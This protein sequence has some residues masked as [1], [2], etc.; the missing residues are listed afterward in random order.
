MLGVRAVLPLAVRLVLERRLADATGSRVE[1]DD[2]DLGLLYGAVRLEGIAFRA[3]SPEDAGAP[4]AAPRAA[5]TASGGSTDPRPTTPTQGADA[6]PPTGPSAVPPWLS[7]KSLEVRI[8]WTGLWGRLLRVQSLVLVE[9]AL[10]VSRLEGGG[11]DVPLPRVGGASR[12]AGPDGGW[13]LAV[14]DAELR[15]GRVRFRDLTVAAPGPVK[16]DL[17]RVELSDLSLGGPA[18][19]G[20]ARLV[21]EG[22]IEGAP[23]HAEASL[24]RVASGPPQAGETN[25]GAAQADGTAPGSGPDAADAERAWKATASLEA[26]GVPIRRARF[27]L[28]PRY[29]PSRRWAELDGALDLDLRGTYAP[30][31]G[32]VVDGTAALRDVRVRVRDEDRD[33]VAWRRLAVEAKRIDLRARRAE[34]ASLELDGGRLLVRTGAGG[35]VPLLDAAAAEPAAAPAPAADGTAPGPDPAGASGPP[36]DEG[37]ATW[38]GTLAQARVH[39]S[40]LELV[41]AE[42]AS[43]AWSVE[44]RAEDVRPDDS[45]PVHVE[46]AKGDAAIS[47]EG[48][49]RAAPPGGALDLHLEQLP[50]AE[51]LHDVAPGRVPGLR[52]GTLAGRLHLETPAD[53]ARRLLARGTLSVAD[54]RVQAADPEDFALRWKRVEAQLRDTVVPLDGRTAPRIALASLR[55]VGPDLVVRRTA[56]GWQLPEA[57]AGGAAPEA[58]PGPPPHVRIARVE[59]AGARL[60]VEDRSVEPFVRE[61]VEGATASARDVRWPALRAE[62]LSGALPGLGAEPV[63]FRGAIDP[64]GLHLDVTASRVALPPLNPYVTAHSSYAVKSGD[65]SLHAD[66]R[67]TSRALDADLDLTL[68]ALGL[69]DTDGRF[70]KD[71][72][73]SLAL[74]KAILSDLQGDIHLSLPIHRDRAGVQLD[75]IE[76]FATAL[77]GAIL[78]ALV[79]PLK[80]AGAV[81][82][83]GGEVEAVEPTPVAYPAGGVDPTA[84]GADQIGKLASLLASKPL[85]GLS[86]QPVLTPADREALATA[87]PAPPADVAAGPEEPRS[88]EAL[89]QA[90]VRELRRRLREDYGVSDARI[91]SVAEAVPASGGIPRI[92]LGLAPLGEAVGASG[93]PSGAPPGPSGPPADGST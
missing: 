44:A 6:A 36:H 17:D 59:V 58:E 16:L 42:G 72:G 54:G 30:A 48:T 86:L 35:G 60:R 92:E 64:A 24:E 18:Y 77:H 66:V 5:T 26:E 15:D 55:A 51:L 80:I 68:H 73:V 27:Y 62:S 85:L 50:L 82:N 2:V 75:L 63:R 84:A 56:Q 12:S 37:D 32:P 1:I 14:D 87:K 71:F 10:D 49:L 69:Q 90:R 74:A 89:V 67:T 57:G 3:G 11:L 81:V 65:A 23:V 47:A 93:T 28:S 61:E 22:A 8:A 43:S 29:A 91:V 83:A 39:G 78:N 38:S 79:S 7:A 34:L 4:G 70:R 45:F 9:P 20:P 19:G 88:A 76:T 13:G 31:V 52:A 53:G 33:V 21:V 40:T 41:D 25:A 46:L